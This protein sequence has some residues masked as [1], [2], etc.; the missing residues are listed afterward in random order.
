MNAQLFK[1]LNEIMIDLS[2]IAETDELQ[3]A[4]L[5][6]QVALKQSYPLGFSSNILELSETA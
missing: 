1:E 4:A 3:L 5:K 6:F 2:L